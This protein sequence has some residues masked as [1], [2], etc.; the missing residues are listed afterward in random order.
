MLGVGQQSKLTLQ[1]PRFFWHEEEFPK[2]NTLSHSGTLCHV[3]WL[4][5]TCTYKYH[6]QHVTL[7]QCQFLA[8]LISTWFRFSLV[9]PQNCHEQ[10]HCPSPGVVQGLLEGLR[11]N[12]WALKNKHGS[13]SLEHSQMRW[14]YG[15]LTIP[16]MESNIPYMEDL[17]LIHFLNQQGVPSSSAS[18][19]ATQ[20]GS[21][22]TRT[23][24]QGYWR[25]YY[26]ALH[27]KKWSS[28]TTYTVNDKWSAWIVNQK[29]DAMLFH[30]PPLLSNPLV[31]DSLLNQPQIKLDWCSFN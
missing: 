6:A 11:R 14:M 21:L 28:S 25:C 15:I 5:L 17:G 24:C 1:R 12:T 30:L 26:K 8:Y 27:Q 18:L 22:A 19:Q 29:K 31:N 3:A 20:L 7:Y 4:W 13:Y 9:Y 10:V 2:Q 16:Y 23:S